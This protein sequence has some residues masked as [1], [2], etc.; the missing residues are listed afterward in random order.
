[1]VSFFIDSDICQSIGYSLVFSLNV[2][3]SP[4]TFRII[5]VHKIF[6]WHLFVS[7]VLFCVCYCNISAHKNARLKESLLFSWISQNAFSYWYKYTF[8]YLQLIVF[9]TVL[10]ISDTLLKFF[11]AKNIKVH[12]GEVNRFNFLSWS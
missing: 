1:M 4:Q 7:I 2:Q 9:S 10:D 3:H 8:Q 5:S 12:W 11:M 6:P